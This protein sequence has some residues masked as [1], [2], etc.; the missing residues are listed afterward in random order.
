M[1][2]RRNRLFS[3]SYRWMTFAAKAFRPPRPRGKQTCVLNGVGWDGS[4]MNRRLMGD[5]LSF[6]LGYPLRSR[7][8]VQRRASSIPLSQREQKQDEE[9]HECYCSGTATEKQQQPLEGIRLGLLLG[10]QRS[11]WLYFGKCCDCWCRVCFCQETGTTATPPTPP[12]LLRHIA[13]CP[14]ASLSICSTRSFSSA[15]FSP[16]RQTL[17]S[18]QPLRYP[19]VRPAHRC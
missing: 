19:V 7:W 3:L 15:N 1:T 12:R 13:E 8:S 11:P 5:A 6:A 18:A 14:H 4:S 16:F 10:H 17:R 2:R 9:N